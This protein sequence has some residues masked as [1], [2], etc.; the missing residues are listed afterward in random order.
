M[1]LVFTHGILIRA[2]YILL[3]YYPNF[4]SM[5]KTDGIYLE[6]MKKQEELRVLDIPAVKNTAIFDIS[7]EVEKYNGNML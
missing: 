3:N 7:A 1:N 5:S 2:M 6:I 4:N